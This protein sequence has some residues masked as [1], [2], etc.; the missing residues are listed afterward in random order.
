ML[1]EGNICLTHPVVDAFCV[2]AADPLARLAAVFFAVAVLVEV[3]VVRVD[4]SAASLGCFLYWIGRYQRP[5]RC[6]VMRWDALLLA[7]LMWASGE[8][9]NKKSNAV[10]NFPTRLLARDA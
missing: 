1:L 6:G 2:S 9:M 8:S 7:W 4:G 5:Y 10:L 3:R